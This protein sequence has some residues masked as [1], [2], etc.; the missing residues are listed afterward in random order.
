MKLFIM[1]HGEAM[2]SQLDPSQPLS[3]AGIFGI[4]NLASY[5]T[6]LN[7]QINHIIHS[8][9]LRA[10]MTAKIM[11]QALHPEQ[12]TKAK[13]SLDQISLLEETVHLIQELQDNTLLIGHMPF[14]SQLISYLSTGSTQHAVVCFSP[15]TLVCLEPGEQPNWIINWVLNPTIVNN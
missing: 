12:V 1:R 6:T 14:V 15:G 11:A 10:V 2:S 9:R 8:P 3:P 4:Q 5:L 7:L 13:N